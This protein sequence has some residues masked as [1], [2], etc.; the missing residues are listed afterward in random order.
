MARDSNLSK[1]A[2]I[3]S[4]YRKLRKEG[5]RREGLALVHES[6]RREKIDDTSMVPLGQ[7]VAAD[8]ENTDTKIFVAG[9]CM[10]SFFLPILTAL[11]WREGVRLD[12]R[13]GNFD[14]ILQDLVSLDW[15]PDVIVIIPW[16]QRILAGADRE[17]S[18]RI[19]SEMD[20]LMQ[21]WN[22][23]AKKG[24][25]LLQV[26][27]DWIL[28]GALGYTMSARPGGDV[29]IV[30]RMNESL[31]ELL[32]DGAFFVDLEQVSATAG[33]VHFY[34]QRN[35]YWMKQPFTTSGLVDLNR[36][37]WAGVRALTQGQKKLLIL[38][39]DNTLW[40]G[41]VAETGPHEID[42]GETP[43]GEAFRS[44]QSYVK[45]LAKNGIVLA[46]CSK[47]NP[48]DAREPFTENPNMLLKLDDFAAFEASW[49]SKPTAI[50]RIAD[51]LRLG[52]DSFVF[53]D[54]NPAEREHVR[55][56]LPEIQVVEVSSDP[57]EYTAA[58]QASLS[59]EA[60]VI[61]DADVIRGRQYSD[62]RERRILQESTDSL[63]D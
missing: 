17:V 40:G 43:D 34:D 29:S 38:D 35:Y 18:E 5:A 58:L 41:I 10:A 37:I 63:E 52:L 8:F 11:G 44:F 39:L 42:I 55:R 50:R 31:K 51:E 19:D 14:N 46:V 1:S 62:E 9:Q 12:V 4:R 6:L 33:H 59:F 16:H 3:I 7:M 13:E 36:H 26:G 56:E 54:D 15:E 23:V 25:K 30:R 28:P 53:F 20:F 32:P 24:A 61:T 57:S 27:Y 22:C 2:D 60:V 48:E 21:I 45:K 47:N 49:D